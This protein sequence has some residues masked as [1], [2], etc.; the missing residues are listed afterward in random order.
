MVGSCFCNPQGKSVEACLPS[1]RKKRSPLK[2][3]R[4]VEERKTVDLLEFEKK[5][6]SRKRVSRRLGK[7]HEKYFFRLFFKRAT[8]AP[9]YSSTCLYMYNIHPGQKKGVAW[10]R[11][12]FEKGLFK[13][14][15]GNGRRVTGL[16][17][18]GRRR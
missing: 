4:V 16:S 12:A 9:V 3:R 14:I 1:P 8:R 6:D 13:E 2:R 17:K 15:D 11:T 18:V 5:G 10:N 7:G